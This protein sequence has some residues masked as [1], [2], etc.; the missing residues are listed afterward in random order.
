VTSD[1]C[2]FIFQQLRQTGPFGD[3][4]M[5]PACVCSQLTL[6]A[7]GFSSR[8]LTTV[9]GWLAG[10]NLPWQKKHASSYTGH[11]PLALVLLWM[12]GY[13]ALLKFH[14]FFSSLSF[15]CLGWTSCERMPTI[16]CKDADGKTE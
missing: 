3:F 7:Q 12:V 16:I 1:G 5:T 13:V 4:S 6:F 8:A 2:R 9:A 10:C 14:F 11:K 15:L